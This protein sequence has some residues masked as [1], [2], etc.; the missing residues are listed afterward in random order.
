MEKRK[1]KKQ[2]L[3]NNTA[4]SVL[5]SLIL[6]ILLLVFWFVGSNKELFNPSI[7]PTP[8]KMWLQLTRMIS[9]GSL[10]EHIAV[11]FR[12]VILGYLLGA[13]SGVFLGVLIGLYTR[14]NQLFLTLIGLLRPI[15]PIACIPLFILMMGIGETSKTAL[16]FIGAFWPCLLNT[17][18]GIHAAN[19]KLIE[20]AEVFGKNKF[21]I[22]KDIV[23]PSA[24][25]SIFTGLRLGISTSWSCVVAAE[26][27]ASNVGVG[28]LITYAR[29]MSKPAMLFIGIIAIGLIGLLIDLVM[30]LLQ[31]KVVYWENTK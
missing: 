11:S 7:I 4:V 14:L 20:V 23:L 21:V 6:P 3:P 24:V 25:P 8:H 26:M 29:E 13:A 2:I 28:Y 9:D 27:I 16:I 10:L 5:I 22:L 18:S 17:I 1:R 30:Q 19:P 31:K 15:P 12:R